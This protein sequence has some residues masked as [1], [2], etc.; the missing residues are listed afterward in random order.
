MAGGALSI[1]ASN[2]AAGS[3]WSVPEGASNGYAGDDM[4]VMLAQ[5][6][7][8]GTID[9]TMFIQYL[10]AGASE[11]ASHQFSF[12]SETCGCDD[13]TA[14]NFDPS[15]TLN[16]GSCIY[17]GCTDASACNF[18][19]GANEDDGS[20]DFCCDAVTSSNSD[21]GVEVELHAVGG[22]GLRTYRLCVTTANATDV[23]SAVS[24]YA[25]Y[26][27]N[28]ETTTSF[29]QYEGAGGGLTQRCGSLLILLSKCSPWRLRLICH[30]WH[31]PTSRCRSGNGCQRQSRLLLNWVQFGLETTLPFLQV[32]WRL[33]H[34]RCNGGIA[35]DDNRV[36]SALN[37]RY[38]AVTFMYKSSLRRSDPERKYI[39]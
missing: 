30:H 15:V 18:D 36:V 28:I 12:S 37:G 21:Y 25:D 3:G 33:V 32:R 19:S 35:G 4:R 24:G 22:M 38:M 10:A 6:T 27:L 7:T 13:A 20:C 8:D 16:D 9:G 34:L 5:V 1:N 2:A 14:A 31:R 11:M 17:P 26:P 39:L 29:Y 23:L